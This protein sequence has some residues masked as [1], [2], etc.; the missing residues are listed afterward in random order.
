VAAAIVWDRGFAGLSLIWSAKQTQQR[1][2]EGLWFVGMLELELAGEGVQRPSGE[3]TE[4][5]GRSWNTLW[6]ITDYK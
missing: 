5:M 6:N 2:G 1:T 3:A 4:G